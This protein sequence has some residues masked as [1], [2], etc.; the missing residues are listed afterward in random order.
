MVSVSVRSRCVC[1]LFAVACIARAGV[2]SAQPTQTRNV[3]NP[4]LAPARFGIFVSL[5]AGDTEKDIDSI[6]VPVGQRLILDNASVWGF[7]SSPSDVLDEVWLQAKGQPAYTLLDPASNEQ[8]VMNG[9]LS[10]IAAYNRPFKMTFE[11]GETVHAY[12]YFTGTNGSKQVNIYLQGHY[13]TP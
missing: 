2:A 9:G 13:V 12:V 4:D 1:A 7:S 3:D 11:A 10:G 5:Q 6:T 8:R